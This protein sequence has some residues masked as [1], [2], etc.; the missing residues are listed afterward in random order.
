MKHPCTN[1]NTNLPKTRKKTL[2]GLWDLCGAKKWEGVPDLLSIGVVH[3]RLPLH[4]IENV[5]LASTSSA[6]LYFAIIAGTSYSYASASDCTSRRR[7][8]DSSPGV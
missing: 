6:G 7:L 2:V 1:I 8:G 4:C 3:I 5:F